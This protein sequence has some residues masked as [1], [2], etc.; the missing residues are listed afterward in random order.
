MKLEDL[1]ARLGGLKGSG[2]GW[3]K[4][5]AEAGVNYFTI[6]RIFRGDIKNPGTLTVDRLTEALE[7][8]EQ[9]GAVERTQASS[10]EAR[11]GAP[12]AAPDRRQDNELAEKIPP[13]VDR[14]VE[15][16]ERKYRERG[17]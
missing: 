5:A 7:R 10:D 8:L 3:R 13:Q 11:E 14:R 1:V 2:G 16:R 17:H 12:G 4:L 6:A 9:S 15:W